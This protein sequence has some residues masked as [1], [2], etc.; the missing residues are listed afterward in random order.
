MAQLDQAT[1]TTIA[2]GDRA[3]AAFTHLSGLAGYLV[4]L[5]GVIVPI[6]IW[7]VKKDHPVISGIARQAVLL[8][9]FVF[10][11]GLCLGALFLTIFLIP[12]AILGWAVLGLIALVLPVIGAI[13][14]ND[15]IYYRY[16]VV[17][18]IR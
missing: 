1:V 11:I 7:V 3:T 13:K 4:P 5:G 16:P 2:D 6:I 9:V 17:G 14:A 10:I 8:N 18:S 12:V 15:G